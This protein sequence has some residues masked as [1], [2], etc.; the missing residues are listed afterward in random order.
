MP[1]STRAKGCSSTPVAVN[2]PAVNMSESPGKKK[3]KNNPF[4]M[5]TTD[6]RK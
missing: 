2:K 3:P 5:K 6:K 1:L 4:S